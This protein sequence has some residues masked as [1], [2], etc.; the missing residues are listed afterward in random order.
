[1]QIYDKITEEINEYCEAN[2]IEDVN[3]FIALCLLSGF[4]IHR[5]GTSPSDNLK[6]E[7]GE[8]VTKTEKPV[9]K[10]TKVRVIKREKTDGNKDK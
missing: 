5:Y 9:E 1:M 4:N 6:R 3:G 10:K 2:K 7:K 8:K